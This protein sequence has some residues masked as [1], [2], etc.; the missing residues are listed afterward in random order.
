MSNQINREQLFVSINQTI[1]ERQS[2]TMFLRSSDGHSFAIAIQ[3]GT[4]TGVSS[5]LTVGNDAVDKLRAVQYA[6]YTFSPRLFNPPGSKPDSAYVSLLLEGN[7]VMSSATTGKLSAGNRAE[8][9]KHALAVIESNLLDI[10]GPFSTLVLDDALK[11][12][13]FEY[14]SMDNIQ[15]FL[16]TLARDIDDKEQ[17]EQ[18]I[19]NT[20]TALK[21]NEGGPS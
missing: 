12:A 17:A 19:Q 9:H 3:N 5:G 2:G 1:A 21:E 7:G 11:S 14:A 16:S 6:S 15:P 8:F 10:L 13:S 20:M 18:F 4:I